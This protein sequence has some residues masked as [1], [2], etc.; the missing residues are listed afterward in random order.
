MPVRARAQ[1]AAEAPAPQAPAEVR[2][3]IRPQPARPEEWIKGAREWL[4]NP[5]ATATPEQINNV[6]KKLE[7]LTGEKFAPVNRYK[8]TAEQVEKSKQ[9]DKRLARM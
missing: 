1:Q 8:L 9:M 4:A 2:Q 5:P 6:G 7:E 3:P